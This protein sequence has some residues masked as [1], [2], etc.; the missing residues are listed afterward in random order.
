MTSR[1]PLVVI[2]GASSGIGQAA[3]RRFSQ[4][5]HPL[6]LLARRLDAM[7]AM[8]L[9]DALC[10]AV[11]VSDRAALV[12]A[13]SQGED[14]FGPVGAL[15]NNAGVMLLGSVADQEPGE[16]DRM[17]S[18][19][20]TGVLNG[21]HAVVSGM[22]ARR[23]GTIIN[24]SSIAGLKSFPNHVAYTGT[25]FAVSGL[26]ENLREELAPHGVRVVTIEPGAVDTELLG[27]TTDAGIISDYEAWKRDIGGALAADDVA[28]AIVYAYQQP[29][30]VCIREIVLAATRQVA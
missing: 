27:H 18:V 21:V 4:L 1:K 13:V 3:A 29:Q 17:L 10:I 2:T 8:N 9:P 23:A 12:A 28:G 25:K 24:I 15:V 11:D 20:V 7:E 14:S 19:N 6:L 16:W 5:G 30:N 26:S 22:I